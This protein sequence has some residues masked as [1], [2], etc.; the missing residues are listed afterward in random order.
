VPLSDLQLEVARAIAAI[1][2]DHDLALAGGGAMAV[3]GIGDRTTNDLDYFATLAAQVDAIRPAI[4]QA[5][6]DAALTV[7]LDRSSSGFARYIVTDDA[8]STLLDLAY[9][10]RLRPAQPSRLGQV[11]D[12]D[13]LAADKTLAL[14]GRAEARDF[15]DVFRLRSFYSRAR[16]CELATEKDRGFDREMFLQALVSIGRHDR[17][18]FE[19]S[20]ADLASLRQEFASWADELGPGLRRESSHDPREPRPPPQPDPPDL[21]LGP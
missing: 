10:S 19:V 13:E 9:D 1:S 11:L 20:D 16:L 4:E 2:E 12:R 5:L 21:D 6:R 18:E 8:D 15:V 17:S 14:F 7:T 3:L